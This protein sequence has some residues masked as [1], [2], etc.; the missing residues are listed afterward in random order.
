MKCV[1]S[2]SSRRHSRLSYLARLDWQQY[3]WKTFIIVDQ[4]QS[5]V[6]AETRFPVCHGCMT[7]IAVA[8]HGPILKKGKGQIP[9]KSVV[10]SLYSA[11]KQLAL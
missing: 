1:K 8:P 9:Q 2:K 5:S 11:S 10:P 7:E 4:I 6:Q 3:P